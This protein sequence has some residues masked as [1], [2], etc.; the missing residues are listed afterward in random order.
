MSVPL[1]LFL[2][3]AA[4]MLFSLPRNRAVLPLLMGAIFIGTYQEIEIGPCHFSV[5]RILIMVGLIRLMVKGERI[6]GRLNSLDR[7]MVFWTVVLLGSSFFHASGAL[8]YRLGYAF[9]TFG[10]YLLFRVFVSEYDDVV[11]I[12][13]M[14][15]VLIVPVAAAMLFEKLNGTNIFDQLGGSPWSAEFRNGHYRAR[16]P[17]THAILAGTIG[18]AC[19]PMALYLWQKQRK[20]ACAGLAAAGTIIFASGSSGPILSAM[21]VLAAMSLWVIRGQVKAIRWLGIF[22]LFL[23]NFIMNDPVYFLVARIDI[24]GGSTGFYRAQLIKST[25][26]HFNEWWFAG[27]DYTRHW[28][29]SGI[30]ANPNSCDITNHYIAMGVMGGLPLM[31]LFMW[32]FYAAFAGVG[33]LLRLNE[34][35]PVERPFLM[36]TLGATLFGHATTFFSISYFDQAIIFL[37]LSLANIGSLLTAQQ[38]PVT[39]TSVEPPGCPEDI[40]QSVVI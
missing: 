28:M 40:S 11:D 37:Y 36:W 34:S 29:L 19:L 27:T 12:F 20:I 17:F 26:E 38:S 4:G 10:V 39:A 1:I 14:V 22:V 15:C 7:A 8:V 9:D 33:R 2:V 30:P 31:L 3:V 21:S 25:I 18:A 23:L 35:E 24:T 16:G 6:A 13:K 32:V 5:M